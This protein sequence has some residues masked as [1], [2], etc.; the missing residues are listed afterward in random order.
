MIKMKENKYPCA[1]LFA[2]HMY[3]NLDDGFYG[4]EKKATEILKEMKDPLAG[5][6]E[7]R[8]LVQATENL[9]HHENI[10][11]VI[12]ETYGSILEQIYAAC[13]Y[14][15]PEHRRERQE[16]RASG[17]GSQYYHISLCPIFESC[18][19]DFG[20]YSC[21]KSLYILLFEEEIQ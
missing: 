3:N 16:H 5:F 21:P 11:H 15:K 13:P 10:V 12:R 2:A 14:E 1:G 8:E 19:E 6:H 20:Y 18:S 7:A 9:P 17:W 4:F